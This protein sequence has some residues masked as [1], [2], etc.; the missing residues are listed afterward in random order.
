MIAHAEMR[1]GRCSC[2]PALCREDGLKEERLFSCLP[3]PP[4]D[5]LCRPERNSDMD[6]NES[7]PGGNG[8]NVMKKRIRYETTEGTEESRCKSNIK[9]F[10]LSYSVSS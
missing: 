4:R 9:P 3:V 5:R 1:E 10:S 8:E 2:E 6:G 7:R